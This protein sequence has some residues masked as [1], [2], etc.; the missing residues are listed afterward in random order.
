MKKKTSGLLIRLIDVVLIL[1]FG[2]ISISQLEQRSKIHLPISSETKL[3]TPDPE[4]LIRISVYPFTEGQ[5]GFLVEN[6]TQLIQD[7]R[8][9]HR[10]LK[11][12]KQFFSGE[13]RVKIY[14]EATS[15]IKYTMQVADLCNQMGL[16]KSLVLKMKNRRSGI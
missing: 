2:F 7:V 3:S 11:N 9:L 4:N 8:Q 10:Y 16:K 15:P 14:S 13:I 6:E 5:W 12:K 1:L